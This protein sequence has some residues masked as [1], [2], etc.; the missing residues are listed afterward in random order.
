M[1][2]DKLEVGIIQCKTNW[3]DNAQIPMLWEIVYSSTGFRNK[4]ITIG[5]NGFKITDF[6]KFFYAF[7]TVPSG[8]TNY[9]ASGLPVQRVYNLSGGNYWGKASQS[10]IAHSL[11]E[12]YNKNFSGWQYGSQKKDVESALQN[13]AKLSYFNIS[14]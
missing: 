13:K 11:K 9:K 6:K 8:K 2:F 1:H 5:K 3:N 4:N 7:A 14:L 12:I 10:G